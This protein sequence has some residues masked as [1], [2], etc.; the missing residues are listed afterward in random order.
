MSNEISLKASINKKTM[1]AIDYDDF[2]RLISSKKIIRS[3]TNFLK[4]DLDIIKSGRYLLSV[5]LI[6]YFPNETF[7]FDTANKTKLLELSGRIVTKYYNYIADNKDILRAEIVEFIE[8][9]SD[10]KKENIC[11][12]KTLLNDT[13]AAIDNSKNELIKDRSVDELNVVEKEFLIH[14][15]NQQQN[16]NEKLELLNT[17]C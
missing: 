2:V 15:N 5:F 1:N 4:E 12:L 14:Y 8:L 10:W 7:E 6:K 13:S 3:A 11:S 17:R 16:I 9:F